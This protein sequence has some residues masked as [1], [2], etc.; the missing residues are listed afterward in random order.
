MAV[1]VE[2]V[3]GID[4]RSIIMDDNISI[5]I[6]LDAINELGDVSTSNC[7]FLKFMVNIIC[8]MSYFLKPALQKG[9]EL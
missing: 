7:I 6:S 5:K 9:N 3:L 4:H 1:E 8:Q 2:C